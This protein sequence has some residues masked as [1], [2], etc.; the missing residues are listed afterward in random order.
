M[1]IFSDAEK[2]VLL[3]ALMGNV[4]A[5]CGKWKKTQAWACLSCGKAHWTSRDHVDLATACQKM[6]NAAEVYLNRIRA[7]EA[8]KNGV[9]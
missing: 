4:C 8:Q 2:A 6:M 3:D 7:Y 1:K 5:I 9:A